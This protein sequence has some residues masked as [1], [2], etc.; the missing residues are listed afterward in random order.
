LQIFY[1]VCQRKYVVNWSIFGEDVNKG[2]SFFSGHPFVPDS[3]KHLC[4][5]LHYCIPSGWVNMI[6]SSVSWEWA[7]YVSGPVLGRRRIMRVAYSQG[8]S[9]GLIIETS[10]WL[11]MNHWRTA[12]RPIWASSLCR[13]A[14]CDVWQCKKI[15]STAATEKIPMTFIKWSCV[16]MRLISVLTS[17]VIIFRNFTYYI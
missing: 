1:K 7:Y 12:S 9:Y 3:R 11:R 16:Y 15:R 10:W 14:V 4:L 17:L 2:C 13:G 5:W 8:R 6:A